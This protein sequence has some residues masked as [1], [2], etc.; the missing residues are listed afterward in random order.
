MKKKLF[1]I[2]SLIM[3]LSLLAEAHEL[4]LQPDKFYYAVG[5]SLRA[6]FKIGNNFIAET[7]ATVALEKVEF[8]T[9]LS[10]ADLTSK[11]VA[12]Q[13]ENMLVP[14]TTE[15]TGVITSQTAVQL[16]TSSADV[17]NSYLK[18]EGL[19]DALYKRETVGALNLP[20]KENVTYYTKLIVQVGEKRDDGFKKIMRWPIEIIP[21]K[22]PYTLIVGEVVKFKILSNGKPLFGAK[23]KVWNRENNRTLIQPV[24]TQQDGTVEA[25]ISNRGAWMVTVTKIHPSN[26]NGSDWQSYKGSLVFGVR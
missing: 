26:K 21:E 12:N 14:L 8:H 16:V 2:L 3:V 17:F 25:R 11:V 22:N 5:D 15:G 13:K 7:S 19:D 9:S 1:H 4:W 24:Y 6:G 10:V 18:D 20:G 23:V